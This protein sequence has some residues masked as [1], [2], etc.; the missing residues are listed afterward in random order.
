M[1]RIKSKTVMSWSSRKKKESSFCNFYFIRRNFLKK[2]CF[3]SMYSVLNKLSEY[4]HSHISKNLFHTLLLFVFKIVKS[5][6]CILHAWVF[7]AL[8]FNICNGR[9]NNF[10]KGW[11]G[12]V[13]IPPCGNLF[14][15]LFISSKWLGVISPNF[16]ALIKGS[17]ATFLHPYH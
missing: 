6:Q 3:I 15:I 13:C 8:P 7:I 9:S 11:R 12:T 1:F 4:V 14:Y 10:K 2:L 16:E 17:V 5:L